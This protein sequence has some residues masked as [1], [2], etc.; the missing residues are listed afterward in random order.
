MSLF[1]MVWNCE[2]E[3]VVVPL[4]IAHEKFDSQSYAPMISEEKHITFF[5]LSSLT[6]QISAPNTVINCS[7]TSYRFR[8]IFRNNSNQQFGIL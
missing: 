3:L 8:I 6:L 7:Q 5:Q 1:L 4:P 2:T